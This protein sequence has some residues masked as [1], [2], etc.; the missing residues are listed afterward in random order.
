M[1]NLDILSQQ[2]NSLVQKISDF[3]GYKNKILDAI[4]NQRFFFFENNE[5]IIFDCKTALIW[6]NLNFFPYRNNSILYS[7][8]NEYSD[9]RTLIQNTNDKNFGKLHQWRVPTSS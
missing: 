7:S 1:A 4:K 8:R 3:D 5:K 2:K 9:V 6:A